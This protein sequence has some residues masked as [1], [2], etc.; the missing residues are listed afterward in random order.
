MYI[1]KLLGGKVFMSKKVAIIVATHKQYF[2][3]CDEIYQ[4]VFVGVGIHPEIPIPNGYVGDNIGENISQLNPF[5]SELTALYWAWKNM[6]AE[7]IGLA[8]YRRHFSLKKDSKHLLSLEELNS[9]LDSKYVFTPTKR[10]YY[11]ESLY[12]HYAHTF[13]EEHLI[14]IKE[15]VSEKYPVYMDN[16]ER[17]FHR[18]WGYMFNMMIMKKEL[19]D[20]YCDWLF[21]ILFELRTRVNEDA[22]DA[23]QCRY[24]GRVSEILFNAWLDYMLES[25][26]LKKSQIMEIPVVSMEKINWGK[27]GCAFLKA[28]FFG[29]KYKKSF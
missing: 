16:L 5:F 25:G 15:I 20:M 10:R 11:V 18:T 19:F 29:V 8:H 12:S 23:F 28:K 14:K 24:L 27:K 3:P 7:Y 13:D 21:D 9:Y 6:E 4:P 17:V 1:C 22:M 2:M 26:E